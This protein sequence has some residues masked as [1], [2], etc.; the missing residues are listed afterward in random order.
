MGGMVWHDQ[1][2]DILCAFIH[3]NTHPKQPEEPKVCARGIKLSQADTRRLG[4]LS[5]RLYRDTAPSSLPK[6][7]SDGCIAPRMR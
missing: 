3:F 4:L 2:F 5:S 1:M 6:R 7:L